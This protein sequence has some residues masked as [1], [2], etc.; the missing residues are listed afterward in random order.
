[1]SFQLFEGEDSLR[2]FSLTCNE[3]QRCLFFVGSISVAVYVFV[4]FDSHF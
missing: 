3:W 4:S 1:M 2:F